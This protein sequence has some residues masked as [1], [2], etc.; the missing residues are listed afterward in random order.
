[1]GYEV[2][3]PNPFTVSG[4][5][6]SGPLVLTA[7]QQGFWELDPGASTYTV[8][9]PAQAAGLLWVF[10]IANVGTGGGVLTVQLPTGNIIVGTTGQ[11]T[12][13][14]QNG[15]YLNFYSN[16]GLGL[17]AGTPTCYAR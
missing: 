13:P 3:T 14:L 9:L 1:M 10:L 7:A 16:G 6:L 4:K 12:V 17:P 2:I 15:M 8:T 11:A 5:V